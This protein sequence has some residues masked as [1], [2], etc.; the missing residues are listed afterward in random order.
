MRLLKSKL[1]VEETPYS[2]Q[3]RFQ[4]I[5][6]IAILYPQKIT[7]LR[8]ARY[9]LR[10]MYNLPEQFEYML[11]VPDSTN[12]LKLDIQ[13][14]YFNMNYDPGAEE[15]MRI[16]QSVVAFNPDILLQLE[17]DP[18]DRLVKMIKLLNIGL[19]IGFGDE[20]SGLNV[21]YSQSKSGFYEK[22]ILNLIALLEMKK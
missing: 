8:I 20:K 13:H 4:T 6:R 7:W 1:A 18:G 22:N 15:S 3:E 14:Q 10:R 17:P 16:Q 9:T 2:F 5:Q 19:K 21:I 11:W 12:E